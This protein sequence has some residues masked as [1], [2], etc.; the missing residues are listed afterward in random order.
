[1][2][3]KVSSTTGTAHMNEAKSQDVLSTTAQVK[4][5][6]AKV[7]THTLSGAVDVDNK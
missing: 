4:N 7:A 6:P 1:M 5:V 2:P 3:N